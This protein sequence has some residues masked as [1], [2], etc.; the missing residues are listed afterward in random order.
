M[1]ALIIRKLKFRTSVFCKTWCH[2]RWTVCVESMK[3]DS[4]TVNSC[5][6]GVSLVYAWI[7]FGSVAFW[8]VTGLIVQINGMF[9]FWPWREQACVCAAY[10]VWANSDLAWHCYIQE[11]FRSQKGFKRL[12][13]RCFWWLCGQAVQWCPGTQEPAGK[14]GLHPQPPKIYFCGPQWD[15]N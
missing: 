11:S 14:G 15:L 7:A 9:S 5:S 3:S 2:C 8:S 12:L 1:A 6:C 10:V 13:P 4:W